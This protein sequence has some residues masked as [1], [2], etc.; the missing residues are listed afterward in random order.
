MVHQ[1]NVQAEKLDDVISKSEKQLE[2]IAGR[3]NVNLEDQ[4]K[5]YVDDIEK[6]TTQAITEAQTARD[7]V[8]KRLDMLN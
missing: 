4:D 7:R 6:L 2:N 3:R 8:Q 5:E 1:L